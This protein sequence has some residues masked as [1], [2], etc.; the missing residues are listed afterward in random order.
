MKKHNIQRKGKRALSLLIVALM[1]LSANSAGLLGFTAAAAEAFAADDHG[2]IDVSVGN[3]S[4]TSVNNVVIGVPETIYMVPG[5]NTTVSG[6]YYV[7]N[8]VGQDGNI[9]LEAKNN[10]DAGSIS[11]YAPGATAFSLDV[12]PCI[13]N[14]G[15]PVI[16]ESNENA[17]GSFENGQIWDFSEFGYGSQD[18]ARYDGLQLFINGSGM[19]SN[20]VATI[21]WA[22]TIY[23]NDSKDSGTTYYAFSTLYAPNIMPVGAAIRVKAQASDNVF[24]QEISWL[25]GVHSI[26]ESTDIDK[27]KTPNLMTS[28]QGKGMLGFLGTSNAAFSDGTRISGLKG[29]VGDMYAVFASDDPAT[30]YFWAGQTGS[31]LSGEGQG[32]ADW[33]NGSTNLGIYSFDWYNQD[34]NPD[35]N[36]LSALLYSSASGKITIDT[37]RYTNLNQIPNLGVGLLVT[38]NDGGRSSSWYVADFSDSYTYGKVTDYWQKTEG[39]STRYY[40][41]HGTILGGVAN[42]SNYS[43]YNSSLQGDSSTGLKYAGSWNRELKSGSGVTYAVKTFFGTKNK[44]STHGMAYAFIDLNATQFDKSALRSLIL[45]GA[46]LNKKN[47]TTGTWNV[48]LAALQDAAYTLGNPAATEADVTKAQTTLEAKAAALKASIKLNANGGKLSSTSYSA[49]IGT[50]ES[51]EVS[52]PTAKPTRTGY[53]FMGWATSPASTSPSKSTVWVGLNDTLFAIW[54]PEDVNVTFDNLIDMDAW[55][56]KPVSDGA[57]TE[58]SDTG[59]TLTSDDDTDEAVFYSAPFP[60]E[61]GKA[62]KLDADVVGK[63]WQIYFIF[64]D[65]QGNWIEGND[66][67]FITTTDNAVFT[68]P[69]G[70]AQAV[71]RVDANGIKNSVSLS[72]ISVYEDMGINGSHFNKHIKS[73]DALGEL[74]VP[75]RDDYNFLGWVDKA[76]GKQ[77]AADSI[78]G[79]DTIKLKSVW[80]QGELSLQP[81]KASIDFSLPIKIDVL[82]ND[83]NIKNENITLVGISATED[84]TPTQSISGEYG[85][86][87]VTDG[88]IVYEIGSGKAMDAAEAV[89]Y[90]V[91][92]NI[93]GI[94]VSLTS[95]VTVFP[96]SNVYYEEASISS[97][98]SGTKTNA[99]QDNSDASAVYGYNTAYEQ[100][101]GFSNGTYY[102]ATVSEDNPVITTASFEFVGTGFDLIGACGERTGVQVVKLQKWN[103]SE[104]KTIKLY[105]VDTYYSGD[106]AGADGLLHQTPIL[107]YRI[108]GVAE[109]YRVEAAAVYLSGADSDELINEI[110]ALGFNDTE[111]IELVWMDDA[112]VFNGGSGEV[113]LTS[114]IDGFRV[115][116]NGGEYDYID[117][118]QNPTYYSIVEGIK[119]DASSKNFNGVTGD[120]DA[121][122]GEIYLAKSQAITFTFSAEYIKGKTADVMLSMRAVKGSVNAHITG[123]NARRTSYPQVNSATEMYY[124]VSDAVQ[125]SGEDGT[126]TIMVTN[127][128]DGVLAVNNLKLVN[129]VLEISD[130]NLSG[131]LGAIVDGAVNAPAFSAPEAELEDSADTDITSIL[132]GMPASVSSFLELLLRLITQL[133]S[134]FGF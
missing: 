16:G 4:F 112:S 48:Y 131:G 111:N 53:T 76:L 24:V 55:L 113:G 105:A 46:T 87:T 32:C 126:V 35:S 72:N 124:N 129:G 8:I 116:R 51:A 21:Q 31:S 106:L 99:Y 66:A 50:S 100:S 132:P 121:T 120:F 90:H 84:G 78:V 71:I 104:Y 89:Y 88:K 65:A 79:T 125:V 52:V 62:Y 68:A 108:D 63:D 115:Y 7:N 109:K 127:T 40:G 118:E 54:S 77:V 34:R 103:G 57:I 85:T 60:A 38:D 96:A 58:V 130:S 61:A 107:T 114:Y 119:D 3:S 49:I 37:S 133:L 14:I 97:G 19:P 92:V 6:Q 29:S 22:I 67:P 5:T 13:G 43:D 98:N 101:T 39:D 134:S 44:N 59:F 47:Y 2:S 36:Y 83:V 73:G 15:D 23:Y 122:I 26:N 56:A 75:T 30:S 86:F 69:Q 64:L 18:Y 9:T 117:S 27:R 102:E 94:I 45:Q 91:D 110:R 25:S 95:T 20:S 1:L 128:G 12:T 123:V 41:E 70:T 82:E 33:F 11:I 28:S 80:H 10:A 81:D 74:P 42:N 17:S 93:E